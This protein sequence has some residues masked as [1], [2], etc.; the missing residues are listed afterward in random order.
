MA[1]RVEGMT[2]KLQE[3]AMQEFCRHGYMGASLRTISE[4]A[5]TTPRSI[6][7]RY[8]DKEGLFCALVSEC[9]ETLKSKIGSYMEGYAERP[10]DEQRMLFHDE[11]FDAEYQGYIRDIIE[12]I[13]DN[14]DVVRL[15][16]CKSEGTKY[17]HFVD[18]IVSIDENYTLR[19]IET[20]G[21]DVL[22]SG[23]AT[24][25]LVHLLCSSFI[26]GFF[27][28]VRHDMKKKDAETYIVQLQGFFACGWD[29]LF[30]P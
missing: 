30:N 8:G 24:T 16:V 11:K 9:A 26:H 29:R 20:T 18:E 17:A 14:W 21:N 3:Q 4:N 28:I 5:G 7:T 2:E 19:Y 13:Y 6:Y 25:Q 22:T 15:L 1:K 10:A 12:Y 27:E 23:R